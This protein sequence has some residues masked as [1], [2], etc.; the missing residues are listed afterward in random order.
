MPIAQKNYP[1]RF[2]AR[3]LVD[4]FD[5]TDKFP[6]ACLTLTN[7]L[8]DQANPEIMVSRP[9]VTVLYNFSDFITPGIVSVFITVGTRIYGMVATGRNANKDEPFVYDTAT[10]AF[11]L[12][13]GV[14]AANTPTTQASS[15]AWTPP[16]MAVIGTKIVVTHPGFSGAVGVFFGVLDIAAPLT[17]AWSSANTS[18]TLLTTVP[19]AVA[20]FNNRAY[21]AVANILWFSDSLAPTVITAGTQFLTVGDSSSIAALSGLPAQSLSGGISQ[22]L[23]IFKPTSIWQLYGDAAI[24]GTLSLNFLSLTVGT[25]QPRSV[26]PTSNGTYFTCI[27]G[28][29]MVDPYSLVRELKNAADTPTPDVMVP[30]Q[31]ATT[32]SRVAAGYI[33]N[34]YRVSLDTIV[35][36]AT[37]TNDYW[38][39]EHR[40][41]WNGPHSFPYDCAGQMS[42]FFVLASNAKP[43]NLYKSQAIPDSTSA[44]T[45]NGTSFL[46]LLQSS[47]FPKTGHMAQVQMVESTIELNASG[48]SIPY[49][50]TA[51][52]DQNATINTCVITTTGTGAIWGT[53]TWGD[54]SKWTTTY[55]SVRVY[56]VP[57]TAPVV[58]QKMS[59]TVSATPQNAL[60]IGT[61][62]GRYQDTGYTSYIPVS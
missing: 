33:A 8:F 3:G 25:T 27:G 19:Q 57:W 2:S 5:A 11:V 28:P 59:I 41:R 51:S 35:Q 46:C 55:K 26:V 44:Y 24:T 15:G 31:N 13:S 21:F 62:M 43:G 16:T 50:V 38:F 30:F 22:T 20:N 4:A 56:T 52:D 54:G 10:N 6:G 32:P 1:I 42:N 61:F 12:I 14:T 49:T 34:A 48:A 53:N 39:D 9:G 29:Y 47:Q 7:L 37:V 60:G 58:F 45:D 23:L 36:G 17:P 40:R 18:G